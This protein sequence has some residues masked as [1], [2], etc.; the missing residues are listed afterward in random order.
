LRGSDGT[1]QVVDRAQ[2]QNMGRLSPMSP[3]VPPHLGTRKYL[4]HIVLKRIF[5]GVP[6]VPIVPQSFG[7]G[8]EIK[9][10]V[11]GKYGVP[12]YYLYIHMYLIE[13]T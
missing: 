12:A 6:H 8:E 9:A 10:R 4:Y 13:N 3:R 2:P 11:P 7:N 5:P 1:G